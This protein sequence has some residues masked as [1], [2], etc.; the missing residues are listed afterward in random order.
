MEEEKPLSTVMDPSVAAPPLAPLRAPV[1]TPPPQ[2][3]EARTSTSDSDDS[4]LEEPPRPTGVVSGGEY[5]TS[6]ESRV[7]REQQEKTMQELLMKRR[8]LERLL[9]VHEEEEAAASSAAL[10]DGDDQIVQYAFYTEGSKALLNARIDIAKYS[11]RRAASRLERARRKKD[12][13]DEDMDA[14]LDFVLE[15]AKSLELDCSEIGDDR[16]LSGC[17]FSHDSQLLATWC[18]DISGVAKLWSMPDAKKVATLK[19]HTERLA[20]V[21]FSPVHNLLATASADR[22]ARLWNAEGTQLVTYKGHLDRLAQIA[23][24]PSGKYLG[25][26]S[27]DQ[28]W[29]LWDVETAEE[30]RPQD[31]H[32][33]SVCGIDFHPDGSLVL[34]LSFS[35]NG[36]YLATGGEDNTCRIWDLRKRKS[37]YTIPAH[38]NLISQVK[39]EPQDG[40]FLVTASYDLT[41]KIWSARD[42]SLSKRSLDM[43]KKLHLWIF[44]VT[45][46]KLLL[47]HMTEPSNCGPAVPMRKT[48]QW[49]WITVQVRRIR[50]WMWIPI[51]IAKIRQWMRIRTCSVL[52]RLSKDDKELAGYLRMHGL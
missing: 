29:R 48:R 2:N 41:A 14:E 35:A 27:F 4:D 26:T 19:G 3:G 34:A 1:L 46:I 7:V 40:Y 31:G 20:D 8:E 22:T 37:I 9:K 5:E 28:T 24:H 16:P 38:S 32:S 13:P 23:F 42:L 12:D 10:E 30:L 43:K 11:I 21:Q 39:F 36:Y 6:E 47:Y 17:S 52:D 49:M 50:Q 25:T 45:G 33:G 51:Q 15:Q 44:Q 18:I